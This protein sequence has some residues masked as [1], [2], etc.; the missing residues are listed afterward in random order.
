[1]LLTIQRTDLDLVCYELADG[2]LQPLCE[3]SSRPDTFCLCGNSLFVLNPSSELMQMDVRDSRA[4]MRET[5]VHGVRAVSSN[6]RRLLLQFTDQQLALMDERCQVLRTTQFP[7]P[8]ES[9]HLGLE[10]TVWI[11]GGEAVLG[12]YQVHWS[13]N[14]ADFRSIPWPASAVYVFGDE[15][16]IVWTINE[17]DELWKLHR[18]GEGNMPGCRQEA[19]CRDCM[20]R[21]YQ[22]AQQV[23]RLKSAF[24]VLS[25]DG[26]L[27]GYPAPGVREPLMQLRGVLRFCVH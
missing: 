18:L 6:G 24:L 22:P 27:R 23:A 12:G 5:G 4:V 10:D 19:S 9:L 8:I 20:L 26:T 15:E 7:K 17:R 1:M 3:V 2:T 21:A 11:A 25:N 16:G 13:E 14:F